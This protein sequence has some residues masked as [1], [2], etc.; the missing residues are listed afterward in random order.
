VQRNQSWTLEDTQVANAKSPGAAAIA[1]AIAA[2]VWACD[3]SA[4]AGKLYRIVD[5]KVDAQTYNGY[6]RYHAGCNHCHGQ[7]GAGSTFAPSLVVRLPGIDAFRRV[8]KDGRTNGASVMKAFGDD[9]NIAPY[10]DDIYAYLQARTDG[11]LGPG[12]PAR[13]EN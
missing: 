4:D 11:A 7:D 3:A 10:I 12:R 6:R 1:G 5:G 9:P 2:G 8:V 13:L